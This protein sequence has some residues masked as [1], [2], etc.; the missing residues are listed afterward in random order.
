[1]SRKQVEFPTLKD[2]LK[3]VPEDIIFSLF[4]VNSWSDDILDNAEGYTIPQLS[5]AEIDNL[6]LELKNSILTKKTTGYE[7]R[8]IVAASCY[9]R[10]PNTRNS[11]LLT[12]RVFGEENLDW[13]PTLSP[14]RA[15]GSTREDIRGKGSVKT[16]VL[17]NRESLSPSDRSFGLFIAS[18]LYK[19]MV[20]APENVRNTWEACHRTYS[21]FFEGELPKKWVS[22]SVEW[23]ENI[24][25]Q[26][27]FDRKSTNTAIK[28]VVRVE[29][30]YN[31]ADTPEA[32]MIRYLFSLPLSYSGMHAY[33]LFCDVK[34]KTKQENE[35]LLSILLHP[36]TKN[37]LLEIRAILNNWELRPGRTNT[38]V[39]YAR[40]L[41]PQYFPALQTKNCLALVY[42]LAQIL[43]HYESTSEYSDPTK[44]VGLDKLSDKLKATMKGAAGAIVNEARIRNKGA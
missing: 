44:I 23:L 20:K 38:A 11:L 13:K 1:M 37:A 43:L 40:I 36:L 12:E 29:R 18:F 30:D 28:I 42:C 27:S 33:K 2:V 39:R 32:E 19:A 9:L 34:D 25:N 3:D 17:E 26:F 6:L 35:W 5:D 4:P 7:S 41:G 24:K 10:K 22:P 31:E 15:S 14:A 21:K 16:Q 8:M